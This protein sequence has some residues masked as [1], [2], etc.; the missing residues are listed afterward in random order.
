MRGCLGC[1]LLDDFVEGLVE[2]MEEEGEEDKRGDEPVLCVA[3]F[4]F[5]PPGVTRFCRPPPGGCPEV[6]EEEGEEDERGDEP[7]LCVAPFAFEPPGVTRFCRPPP[8]G[9][10]EVVG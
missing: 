3:P 5:E 2:V 10:P 4:G 1:T 8:G 7:V 6:V 9:C